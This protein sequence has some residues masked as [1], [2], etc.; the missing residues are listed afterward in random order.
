[1]QGPRIGPGQVWDCGDLL[2]IDRDRCRLPGGARRHGQVYKTDIGGLDRKSVVLLFRI[3][4][5]PLVV[6]FECQDLDPIADRILQRVGLEVD[7]GRVLRPSL[8]QELRILGLGLFTPLR[9]ESVFQSRRNEES[10][11]NPGCLEPSLDSAPGSDLRIVRSGIGND[12]DV[13]RILG[14]IDGVIDV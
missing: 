9:R 10:H 13:E 11:R 12:R 7:P 1:V 4:Q 14:I 8:R 2:F 5:R 3:D 6:P